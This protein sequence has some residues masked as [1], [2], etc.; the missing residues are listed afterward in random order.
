MNTNVECDN[1]RRTAEGI[2]LGRL[3]VILMVL[4]V[5]LLTTSCAL[6]MP[7]AAY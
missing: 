4:T 3:V 7:T 6:L 1:V 2:H 5:A